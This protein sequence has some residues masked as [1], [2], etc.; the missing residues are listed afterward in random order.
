MSSV[1]FSGLDRDDQRVA[2][3]LCDL[4]GESPDEE[5]VSIVIDPPADERPSPDAPGPESV[6][7]RLTGQAAA[8]L[9]AWMAYRGIVDLDALVE[10][11]RE[12]LA[13]V[14]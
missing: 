14:D 3:A 4:Q 10:R 8:D 2:V 9:V 6:S 13:D 7:V 11:R 1:E 5:A 12:E